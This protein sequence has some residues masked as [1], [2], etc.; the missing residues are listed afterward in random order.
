MGIAY[1]AAAIA[2]IVLGIA[3]AIPVMAVFAI[4]PILM[5]IA[6]LMHDRRCRQEDKD[7][8]PKHD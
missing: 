8:K 7:A 4:V 2:M 6:L 5:A 1:G 3:R